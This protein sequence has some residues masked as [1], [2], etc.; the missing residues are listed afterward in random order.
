MQ[1]QMTHKIHGLFSPLDGAKCSMSG[2]TCWH[3]KGV[4][5]VRFGKSKKAEKKKG[6]IYCN[7]FE[8]PY[9]ANFTLRIFNNNM[10][11]YPSVN[12]QK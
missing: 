10:C 1:K 11:L 4:T 5:L 12:S 7:D 2:E 6:E 9:C 3:S 8:I